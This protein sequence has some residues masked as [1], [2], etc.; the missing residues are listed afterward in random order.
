MEKL[1]RSTV[2]ARGQLTLAA[3][4]RRR[5]GIKEED[6]LD[7]FVTKPAELAELPPDEYLLLAVPKR[8]RVL[9]PELE[10][11]LEEAVREF[12]AEQ[13]ISATEMIGKVAKGR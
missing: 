9:T 11:H 13:S 6:V 12:S 1:G 2:T 5:F 8:A 3:D 7:W 4:V 10:Q